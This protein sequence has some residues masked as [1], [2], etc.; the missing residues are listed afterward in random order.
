[1]TLRSK[2]RSPML[3]VIRP[4]RRR[5]SPGDIFIMSLTARRIVF[6]RVIRIDACL[7]HI[8]RTVLVYIYRGL[9]VSWNTVPRLSLDNL[10]LPPIGTA[11]RLW[12]RGYFCSIA[13]LPL[14]PADVLPQHCFRA[15]RSE[16]YFDELGNPLSARGDPC[17]E[18]A[19][20]M[21]DAIAA[22]V[23]AAL[24]TRVT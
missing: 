17:G 22:E 1:M 20:Y 14:A 9:S 16:R 23:N 15:L 24:Q 7:G 4:T 3:Q 12:F 8:P 13:T 21:E 5:P 19:L 18:Y 6:G 2:P 10:L 11:A